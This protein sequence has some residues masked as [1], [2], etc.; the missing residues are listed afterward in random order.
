MDGHYIQPL[1]RSLHGA[2]IKVQC[3]LIVI[4]GRGELL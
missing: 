2:G 4:S 1:A 3:M